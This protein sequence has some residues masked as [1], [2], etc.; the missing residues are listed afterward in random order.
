MRRYSKKNIRVRRAGIIGGIIRGEE[1]EELEQKSERILKR[2]D[3]CSRVKDLIFVSVLV[4]NGENIVSCLKSNV[5]G[6][7][8]DLNKDGEEKA[9]V[10]IYLYNSDH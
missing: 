3:Q 7:Q 1:L 4:E 8:S 2:Q 6:L 5:L 10:E 9:T